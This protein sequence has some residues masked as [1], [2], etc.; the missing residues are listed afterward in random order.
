MLQVNY[1]KVSTY[2]Q[3]I[4]TKSVYTLLWIVHA[5]V[6]RYLIEHMLLVGVYVYVQ[7]FMECAADL[8]SLFVW[9]PNYG[10]HEFV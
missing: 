4:C 8:C 5:F 3:G 2:L 7:Y 6:C 9:F 1:L 10:L